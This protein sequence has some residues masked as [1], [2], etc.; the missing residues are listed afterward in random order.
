MASFHDISRI[1]LPMVASLKVLPRACIRIRT[2]P[3]NKA[4]AT[5]M[6]PN[7]C[8]LIQSFANKPITA[9]GRKATHRLVSSR[10]PSASRPSIPRT[11]CRIRLKYKT[12][13]ARMAPA[14]IQIAR[15]LADSFCRSSP[16]IP[17]RCSTINRC[18]VELTGRY[19]VAP[20]TKPRTIAW[21]SDRVG[22][23]DCSASDVDS[24]AT[25][26]EFVKITADR[27][28]RKLTWQ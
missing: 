16:S 27:R 18:P 4:A 22:R 11:I 23:E 12:S 6:T 7:R 10:S 2:P 25:L 15:E 26:A 9:A 28:I 1:P 5:G 19:S 8:S 21:K 13:T 14:W 20:S 17:I 3:T 24:S